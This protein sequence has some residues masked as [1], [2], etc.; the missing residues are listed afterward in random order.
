MIAGVSLRLL[1][2]IFRQGARTGPVDGPH[3]L[4]KDVEL[5]V[6]RHEAAVLRRANP[7]LRVGRAD[8]AVFAALTRWLP[9]V[10]W[11]YPNRFGAAT[12]Q[13]RRRR[14]GGAD[15][16]GRTRAGIPQGAP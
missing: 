2:Q 12:D 11:T 5:L 16:A 9:K 1:Y 3:I 7:R 15:G 4:P 8:R 13:R 6:L 10:R 14:A